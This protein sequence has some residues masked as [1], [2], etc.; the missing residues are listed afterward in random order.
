MSRMISKSIRNSTSRFVSWNVSVRIGRSHSPANADD[1]YGRRSSVELGQVHQ[2]VRQDG[3]QRGGK[4][5]ENLTHIERFGERSEQRL[6]PVEPLP[7]PPIG[8]PDLPV[9]DRRAEER[10]DRPA[11]SSWCSSVNACGHEAFSQTPPRNESVERN[12]SHIPDWKPHSRAFASIGKAGSS[13]RCASL[14]RGFGPGRGRS[15]GDHAVNG[16]ASEH[17][18]AR[19]QAAVLA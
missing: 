3:L 8:V 6:R 13:S 9:L 10:G 12:G 16:M 1:A 19:P 2:V 15:R 18:G 14:I 5:L 7:A 4:A 11:V 17:I